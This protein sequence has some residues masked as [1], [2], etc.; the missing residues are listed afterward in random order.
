MSRGEG[1]RGLGGRRSKTLFFSLW[2]MAEH[3]VMEE[4]LQKTSGGLRQGEEDKPGDGMGWR[5]HLPK[6]VVRR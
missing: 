4:N 5:G 6:R 3:S 1:G 2:D